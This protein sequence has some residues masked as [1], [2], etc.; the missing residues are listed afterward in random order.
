[1]PIQTRWLNV[2]TLAL[3]ASSLHPRK[4]HLRVASRRLVRLS[5]L[6]SLGATALGLL[7]PILPASRLARGCFE[8]V[9]ARPQLPARAIREAA[10]STLL[11]GLTSTQFADPASTSDAGAPHAHAQQSLALASVATGLARALQLLGAS[12]QGMRPLA[13]A[14]LV[15]THGGSGASAL[16]WL[17]RHR[18]HRRRAR[19]RQR[20][21]AGAAAECTELS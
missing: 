8:C 1:M 20:E 3:S 19:A 4:L 6:P 7:S 14:L 5:S 21:L 16:L 13:R 9:G 12:G 10:A 15:S 11:L 2:P 17:V 18:R